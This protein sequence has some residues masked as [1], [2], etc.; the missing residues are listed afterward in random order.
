MK[1]VH[2][3]Y[4]PINLTKLLL[5][6]YV[7]QEIEGKT[8]KARQFASYEYLQTLTDEECEEV[9]HSFAE[10]E[11]LSVITYD[12]YKHDCKIMFDIIEAGE[13][14]KAILNKNLR[15]GYGETGMGVFDKSDQTF[16]ECGFTEHWETVMKIVKE[17]YPHVRAEDLDGIDGLIM[18]QFELIGSQRVAPNTLEREALQRQLEIREH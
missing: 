14:F 8:T 5:Q 4:D 1:Q 15:S 17:K 12:D 16:Y 7:E 10:R 2:F 13:R 3:T 9:V 18:T 6:M 11:N